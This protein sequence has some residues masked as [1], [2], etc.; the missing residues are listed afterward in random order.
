M[1]YLRSAGRAAAWILAS[2]LVACGGGGGGGGDAPAPVQPT[3]TQPPAITSQPAAAS[4]ITGASA[5]FSVL[6][7]GSAL[8][9]Q[10]QKNGTAIAGAT[11]ASYTVGPLTAGDHGSTYSVVVSNAGGSV[12]SAPAV[13]NL[14]LSADQQ[15]FEA[16]LL[17]P[18]Q[19]SHALRWNLGLS[20]PPINGTH[21]LMVET[22]TMAASPLGLGAQRI[23]QAAP[24][25]LSP[26]LDLPSAE[27]TRVLKDGSIL[28]VPGQSRRAWRAMWA[29]PCRS[30]RWRKTAPRW[31]PRSG[32]ASTRP[33]PWP[34]C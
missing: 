33:C 30:T 2:A 12:T 28:V 29:V 26:T 11:G 32:A 25:S 22:A 10:W 31:P 14:A 23:T 3:V 13:L 9:Y 15:R 24:R 6:A 5:S 20:G 1:K 4:A 21:Y 19:G 8:S 7:S 17:A 16:L 18:G 34:A 27:P